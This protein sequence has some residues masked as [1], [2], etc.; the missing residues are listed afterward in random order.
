MLCC[1]R[2]LEEWLKGSKNA[3][4]D[5]GSTSSPRTDHGTLKI[6]YLAVRP[7]PVEGGAVRSGQA[8]RRANSELWHSLQERENFIFSE[9]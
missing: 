8:C 2:F 9:C 6:N 1:L 3:F 4:T 5:H 7:E